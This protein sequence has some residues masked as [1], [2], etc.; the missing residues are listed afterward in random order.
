M[1][2]RSPGSW[3][4]P[5][6]RAPALAPGEIHVWR[7][8]IDPALPPSLIETRRSLLSPDELARANRFHTIALA[9]R[10][11]LGR[12]ALRLLLAR[13]TGIDPRE[14]ALDI[15]AHGKPVMRRAD[16]P[17]AAPPAFNLSHAGNLALLAVASGGSIG[18]DIE[19]VRNMADRDGVAR[20]FFSAAEYQ[21]YLSLAPEDRT[22][23]FFR[24]WTR[25][26]AFIKAIG[27]GLSRPLRT[28]DVTLG[29][30]DEARLLQVKGNTGEADEWSMHAFDPAPGYV[31]A[32][33]A[34]ARDAWLSFYD[35]A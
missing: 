30:E 27:E 25:K 32:V 10:W 8:S 23:G 7:I 20:R 24:C 2:V 18:I 13:Y 16:A 11:L 6:G 35:L 3:S 4:A 1:R 9:T 12:G 26:E 34:R 17:A 31:A 19:Q 29:P 22:A 21:Q 33:A 28:F 14:I 15:E 5:A